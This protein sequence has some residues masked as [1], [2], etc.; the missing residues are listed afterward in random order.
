MKAMPCVR[1]AHS[2]P[3]GPSPLLAILFTSCAASRSLVGLPSGSQ[4]RTAF[5]KK[6]AI[7]SIV[8][9]VT[10]G[11]FEASVR[12]FCAASHACAAGVATRVGNFPPTMVAAN[13]CIPFTQAVR[14]A[15][16]FVR[17]CPRQEV[18]EQ[19]CGIPADHLVRVP[20]QCRAVGDTVQRWQDR[21]RPLSYVPK[22]EASGSLFVSRRC[23]EA[24][25]HH[26]PPFAPAMST[27]VGWPL[28]VPS[29][30]PGGVSASLMSASPP[31]V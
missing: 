20:V 8:G 16:V 21:K 13:D 19:H 1:P 24:G 9:A 31:P 23:V 5:K 30:P 27:R 28:S 11:E 22:L 12:R 25:H 6:S 26:T 3:M 7:V 17:F 14:P 29:S 18:R 2:C 4:T 15:V 10:S